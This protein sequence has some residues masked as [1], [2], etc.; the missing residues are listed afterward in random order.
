VGRF[1]DLAL[2]AE[3]PT[4]GELSDADRLDFLR[5]LDPALLYPIAIRKSLGIVE[6]SGLELELYRRAK[7]PGLGDGLLV[8]RHPERLATFEAVVILK[9]D[10][11]AAVS[12]RFQPCHF[13]IPPSIPA[14]DLVA[15]YGV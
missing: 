11:Q 5:R 10:S 1:L 8:C 9:A 7:P 13:A 14:V 2:L 3:Q 4:V 6:S 15:S 12:V